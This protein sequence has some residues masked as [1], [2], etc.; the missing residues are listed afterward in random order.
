MMSHR[1]EQPIFLGFRVFVRRANQ[2][3][4][5]SYLYRNVLRTRRQSLRF[6]DFLE[7][8]SSISLLYTVTIRTRVCI[9]NVRVTIS[10]DPPRDGVNLRVRV[11]FEFNRIQNRR[12]KRVRVIKCVKINN[13]QI[14]IIV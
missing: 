12:Q 10:T 13:K 2:R 3:R 1:S 6:F 7:S 8:N 11:R 9:P 5:Y 14:I 4:L